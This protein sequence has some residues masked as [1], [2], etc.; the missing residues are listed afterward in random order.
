VMH[1]MRK[2]RIAVI[3][4]NWNAKKMTL[5]CIESIM[6]T[7]YPD[8]SIIVVDNGSQDGSAEAIR[9]KYDSGTLIENDDNMGFCVANNQAIEFALSAGYDIILVLNNDTIVKN[10]FF[11]VALNR[12]ELSEKYIVAPK[13][14]YLKEPSYF[15]FVVGKANLWAGIFSNPFHKQQN[16]KHIKFPCEMDFASGCCFMARADVFRKVGG[17]DGTFFTYCEDIDLSL[18]LREAGYQIILEPEAAIYHYVG[19]SGSKTSVTGRYYMTRNH[20]WVLRRHSKWYHRLLWLPLMP[21]R[22]AFRIL[23]MLRPPDFAGMKAEVRGVMHGL[24]HR[25]PAMPGPIHTKVNSN[26]HDANGRLS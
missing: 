5:D 19:F 23:K 7:G 25:L 10:N 18:R 17:F 22:S 16:G 15:W 1:S 21:L 9:M 13:I 6:N 8:V 2:N 11:E 3:L 24:F 20:L 12:L 26:R 14:Y 4:V